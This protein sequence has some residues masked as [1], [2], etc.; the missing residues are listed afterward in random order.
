MSEDQFSLEEYRKKFEDAQR[1]N[2]AEKLKYICE[3]Y[4]LFT[5]K[6]YARI[7]PYAR[8]PGIKPFLDFS[9]EMAREIANL[10]AETNGLTRKKK[11]AYLIEREFYFQLRNPY[12]EAYAHAP[13]SHNPIDCGRYTGWR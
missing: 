11:N 2:P 7:G 4:N 12:M 10:E 1:L 9:M 13:V 3:L 5:D 6:R 8:A